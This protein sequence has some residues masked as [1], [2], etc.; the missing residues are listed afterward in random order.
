MAWLTDEALGITML[1]LQLNLTFRAHDSNR[2]YCKIY[3][4]NPNWLAFP[5]RSSKVFSEHLRF[6]KDGYWP[7]IRLKVFKSLTKNDQ[8]LKF[9]VLDYLQLN[10][11]R[12]VC[13]I[14]NRKA[15]KKRTDGHLYYTYRQKRIFIHRKPRK[16]VFHRI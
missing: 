6:K 14:A 4:R 11:V 13:T 15:K 5:N 16:P 10:F 8:F 9:W 2:I 12:R 3:V 1:G 7:E